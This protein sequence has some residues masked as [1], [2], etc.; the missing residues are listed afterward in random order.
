MTHVV[1]A[2]FDHIKDPERRLVLVGRVNHY[3]QPPIRHLFCH[4]GHIPG[5]VSENGKVGTP[6]LG[7]FQCDRFLWRRLLNGSL[8]I[9]TAGT[10][11][12]RTQQHDNAHQY[13]MWFHGCSFIFVRLILLYGSLL[14]VSIT[15][16]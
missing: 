2:G 5:C 13:G 7:E 12:K 14:R 9:L 3:L 15:K 6:C 11:H 10:Q 8:F 16:E 1:L 4:G